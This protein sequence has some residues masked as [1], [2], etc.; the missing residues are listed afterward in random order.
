MLP[1]IDVQSPDA[2]REIDLACRQCGFFAIRNHGVSEELRTDL[3][4]AAIAFFGRRRPTR[5]SSHSNAVALH[6]VV[7]SRS[8]AS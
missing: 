4:A 5:S 1:I 8:V 3:I 6:G 2:P 7:G